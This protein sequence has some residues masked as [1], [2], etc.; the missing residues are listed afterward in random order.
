MAV[1]VCSITL[2][3][4]LD[5]SLLGSSVHGIFQAIREWVA[6]VFLQG[7]FL[8]QGSNPCLLHLLYCRWI[9][10]HWAIGEAKQRW[11]C[12]CNWPNNWTRLKTSWK[13]LEIEIS[14]SPG[15]PSSSVSSNHHFATGATVCLRMGANTGES[16]S[17]QHRET[18]SSL[19]TF[20]LLW[21][22][23]V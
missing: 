20:G 13:L 22:N 16:S 18:K 11:L 4:S 6:M 15:M 1:H 7:I 5:C 10:Y 19:T 2:C 12:D 14:L 3:H 21:S 8:T 23:H 17:E 9:F